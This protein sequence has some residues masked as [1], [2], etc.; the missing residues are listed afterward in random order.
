MSIMIVVVVGGGGG[1]VFPGG[2]LGMMGSLKARRDLQ[3][4]LAYSGVVV[5]AP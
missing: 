1:G 3:G 2:W 5:Y 4:Q